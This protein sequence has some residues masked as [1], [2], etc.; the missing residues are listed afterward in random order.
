MRS[1][2]FT[3]GDSE[4]KLARASSCGADALILDLEDSVALEAKARARQM[5]RDYLVAEQPDGKRRPKI[6]VRINALSTGLWQDDLVAV[7]PGRPAGI[8]LPKPASGADVHQLSVVLSTMEDRYGLATGTLKI[9]AIVTEQAASI[10]AM[11]SYV[12]A[13]ARLAGLTW[14]AEDLSADI[15]ATS[16]RDSFGRLASPFQLA[17][18]LTLFTAVAADAQPIDAVYPE[19]RDLEGLANEARTAARD[20]FT[21]KMAIHPDQVPLINQAFTPTRESIAKAR[22]IFAAF[23][24]QP[25][26]GV[27][28]IDGQM[29]DRPHLSR[30]ERLLARA[31]A[32]S[33]MGD[34]NGRT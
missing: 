31:E 19:F 22:A 4:R 8:V 24:A 17:R 2:L 3:P 27:V 6:W 21:G 9:I 10:L 12:G 18:D 15:G 29:Y 25:G 23:D 20:G 5:T 7:V 34:V 1:M 30:A 32:A 11:P 33:A 26:A 14:G 13:S 28:S 16:T